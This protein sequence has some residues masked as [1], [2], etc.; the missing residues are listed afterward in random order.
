[1]RDLKSR[2]SLE[3]IARIFQKALDQFQV[4]KPIDPEHILERSILARLGE[5]CIRS[6]F[7]VRN[8]PLYQQGYDH[9]TSAGNLRSVRANELLQSMLKIGREMGML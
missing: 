6:S 2:M 3:E 1:M 4:R 8:Y 7:E 9:L 5:Y